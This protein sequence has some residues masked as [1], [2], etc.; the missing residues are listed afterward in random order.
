MLS[1]IGGGLLVALGVFTVYRLVR[2]WR[3]AH[4]RLHGA[5]PPAS[6]AA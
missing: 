2:S 5:D 6:G 4:A 3:T 1:W